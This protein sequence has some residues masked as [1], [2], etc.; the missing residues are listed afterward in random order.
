MKKFLLLV[1]AASTGLNLFAQQALKDTKPFKFLQEQTPVVMQTGQV[2][3]NNNHQHR[4][5]GSRSSV[6]NSQRIGSAGNLFTILNSTCNNL[7]SYDSLGSVVFIHRNDPSLPGAGATNIA[8]YRFDKSYNR[9]TSWTSNIGPITNDNSIDNVSVNGRFPQGVIFNKGGAATDDS[10]LLVYSGTWHNGSSGRWVG[11][12]RGRGFLA[13]D[14]TGSTFNVNIDHVNNDFV[15]VAGG[16]TKGVPGTFWNVNQDYTGTF[17]TGS[18]AITNGI[19]VEKGIW[20]GNDVAWTESKIAQT[21]AQ[22]DNSG[23]LVSI[24]TSFNIAFDPTGMKGWISCLGDITQDADSV[25]DPVFWKTID[26]GA[27]WTG[28]IH[29]DLDQVQGVRDALEGQLLDGTPIDKNA[30]SAFDADLTV[31]ANGNPHLLVVV[32]NGTEYS[33]QPSKNGVW[34]ITYDANGLTGCQWRGIH[35]GDAFTLRGTFSSNSPATTE[36]NRPLISRTPDGNQIFFFWLET[37]FAFFG[38]NDN[39]APNLFGR[40][41]DIPQ[42]KITPLYNITEGDTLWGGQTTNA[43]GGVFGG[44]TFPCVGQLCLVESS[45]YNVPVVFTQVDYNHDPSSGL[46]RDDVPCAFWYANNVNFPFS[47]F[48]SPIDQIPPTITLNGP[49]TVVILVHTSY[50]DSGATAF[51]CT[52]GVIAPAIQGAVDTSATG[53]YVIYY[54]AADAAGN[55]DTVVRTVIVGDV[56][57]AD[58][59]FNFVTTFKVQFTDQSLNIPTAWQW[60]FGNG[61]GASVQNPLK[62]YANADSV[63]HVC[64]TASNSFGSSAPVCKD[65]TTHVGINDPVFSATINMFPNPTTGKVRITFEGGVTHE[66]EVTVYNVIGEGVVSTTKFKA[67]A[68]FIEMDMSS[69]VSGLYFVKIQ[70]AQGTAVKHL[71]VNHK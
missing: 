45:H 47:D 44:A 52:D 55:T 68:N 61:T 43:S 36:D 23:T 27:N 1:A 28:P 11:E 29:V 18:N 65:V 17:A 3:H 30:T 20:N 6:L 42:S 63:Y 13:G 62:T 32:G 24:A 12:M 25:Y 51:D 54:I 46:G 60:N 39:S 57:V 56:P 9:G 50:T 33:I 22:T 53:I 48:N 34:D 35:L 19:V 31:D 40:A 5:G 38:S 2:H 64:L 14:S 67:G 15:A 16:L 10:L 4:S 8:Q 70:N 26:G 66:T 59:S 69:L 7:D 37:D 41:I 71:T 49:D 21:F 58:F